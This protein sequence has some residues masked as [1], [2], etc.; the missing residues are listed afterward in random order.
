MNPLGGAS[1]LAPPAPSGKW[2]K[3]GVGAVPTM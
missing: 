2:K 1:E 3:D